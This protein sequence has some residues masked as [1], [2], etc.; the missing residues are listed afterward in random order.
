MKR[1]GQRCA[2]VGRDVEE[3]IVSEELSNGHLV[4]R[5]RAGLVDAEHGG[6]AERLEGRDPPGQDVLLRDAPGPE[7]QED[8]Q[9]RRKLVGQDGHREG[10]P[11]QKSAQP[12][13]T[14]EAVGND[15]QRAEARTDHGETSHEHGGL[16]LERAALRHQRMQG[17]S[18]ATHL[19]ARARGLHDP[20]AMPVCD[21][22]ARVD[23]R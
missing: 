3:A 13:R 6:G 21:Q 7:R 22:R 10:E 2:G 23:E 18:D 17:R 19:G 9:D 5:Q 1:L 16:P 14:G 11:G 20:H 15:D 12:V 4:E 8:R